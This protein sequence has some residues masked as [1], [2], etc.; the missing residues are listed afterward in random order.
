[1]I[2]LCVGEGGRVCLRANALLLW[3]MDAWR[4]SNSPRRGGLPRPPVVTEY[5][6]S[7]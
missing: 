1:M 5:L 3:L 2:I 4:T 7:Q 6:I